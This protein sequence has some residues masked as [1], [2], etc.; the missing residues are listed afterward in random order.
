LEADVSPDETDRDEPEPMEEQARS[1]LQDASDDAGGTVAD[2]FSFRGDL[3]GE[4]RPQD[5]SSPARQT[6]PDGDANMPGDG[7][8]AAG[9]RFAEAADT[10]DRVR[11]EVAG[12]A[13]AKSE[14]AYEERTDRDREADE[15][16]G[17]RVS[18]PTAATGGS[19]ANTRNA[20]R[21]GGDAETG[22]GEDQAVVVRFRGGILIAVACLAAGVGAIVW[23]KKRFS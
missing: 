14:G 4:T 6:S 8:G 2:K 1:N 19:H 15:G 22:A 13:E 18:V 11:G 9:R 10:A 7:L 23:R 5:V 20:V 21:N 17:R 12:F 16:A 3:T